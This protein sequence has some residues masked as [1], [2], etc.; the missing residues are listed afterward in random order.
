MAFKLV[1]DRNDSGQG[2]AMATLAGKLITEAI[3]GEAE[4]FDLFGKIPTRS[5]PGGDLLRW[6]A[7]VPGMSYYALRDRL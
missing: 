5:F 3:A 7:M 4:R 1:Q 6:P 2:V